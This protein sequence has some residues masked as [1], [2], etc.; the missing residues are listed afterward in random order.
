MPAFTSNLRSSGCRNRCLGCLHIP[1]R[2]CAFFPFPD[3]CGTSMFR[4]ESGI[5][6]S[7]S[8]RHTPKKAVF[9]AF[10]SVSHLTLI[11]S[12]RIRAIETHSN[13]DRNA[14]NAASN[15]SSRSFSSSISVRIDVFGVISM[16]TPDSSSNA[17]TSIGPASR[18]AI[19]ASF[20]P[21]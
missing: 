3:R 6:R 10:R 9:S 4:S 11:V 12:D 18:W 16:M 5:Y 14:A 15:S 19:R 2:D 20:L 13:W 21:R 7:Y 17:S 8:R 1:L